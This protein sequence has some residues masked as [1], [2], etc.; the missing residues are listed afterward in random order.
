MVWDIDISKHLQHGQRGFDLHVRCASA[1][2]RL[3][4]FG[5][6]GAG[7]TQTLKMIAGLVRPDRGSVKLLGQALYCS[8]THQDLSPQARRV[9]YVF[10]DYALF[11][12]LTVRQNIAFGLHTGWR[13]PPRMAAHAAVDHWLAAFHMHQEQQLFPH[14]LSG[15]QRQRTALARALVAEPRALLLDEPFAA[16]DKTLRQRLRDQLAELLA[17]IGIPM[18]LITHDEEDVA[19]LAD[20]VVYLAAGR[21]VSRAQAHA[22]SLEA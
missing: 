14:Q 9:A 10:Q 19:Q 8:A 5:P 13:N 22:A 20:E 3:V 12:H 1:A 7:K 4:L 15:G 16:L 18:L 17:D 2:R 11:P 21:V 6:S